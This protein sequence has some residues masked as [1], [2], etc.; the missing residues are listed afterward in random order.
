TIAAGGQRDRRDPAPDEGRLLVQ[1]ERE[2]EIDELPEG[3]RS[4]RRESRFRTDSRAGGCDEGAGRGAGTVARDLEAW[5][6]VA[7][8]RVEIDD[9]DDPTGRA[10]GEPGGPEP[11][12]CAP[13]GGQEDDR[14]RGADRAPRRS[15]G[16][17]VA[18]RKL[19]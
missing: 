5:R 15:G 16:M 17:A 6:A 18:A 2:A 3:A 13:V 14:V 8:D 7:G 9:R 10:G 11:S 19:E 1:A 12:V 4:S